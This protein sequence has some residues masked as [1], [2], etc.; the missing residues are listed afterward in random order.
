MMPHPERAAEA[1]LGGSDGRVLFE[2]LIEALG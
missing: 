1:R 2:T